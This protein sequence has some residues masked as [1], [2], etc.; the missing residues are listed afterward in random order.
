MKDAAI[1]DRYRT[2]A[3]SRDAHVRGKNA[4]H[5]AARCTVLEAARAKGHAKKE[6][7]D[8]LQSTSESMI[9]VRPDGIGNL[10]GRYYRLLATLSRGSTKEA[11]N[12]MVRLEELREDAV[13]VL[14]FI[15]SGTNA[16]F[17]KDVRYR[18]FL[19]ILLSLEVKDEKLW[20]RCVQSESRK[21]DGDLLRVEQNEK[22]NFCTTFPFAV[23]W[24]AQVISE[25]EVL[26]KIDRGTARASIRIVRLNR[27]L[28]AQTEKETENKLFFLRCLFLFC[29]AESSIHLEESV[30]HL[31][32]YGTR[33]PARRRIQ[34]SIIE[35]SS[36]EPES[37]Y[38]LDQ[39]WLVKTNHPMADPE[40]IP[41]NGDRLPLEASI[42]SEHFNMFDDDLNWDAID[43]ILSTLDLLAP[44]VRHKAQ[45]NTSRGCMSGFSGQCAA[46]VRRSVGN[47]A[48]KISG[49]G[50][51]LRENIDYEDLIESKLAE[52]VRRDRCKLE[53]ADTNSVAGCRL[54]TLMEKVVPEIYYDWSMSN[55][56]HPSKA[57]LQFLP[58]TQYCASAYVGPSHVDKI[59]RNFTYNHNAFN[60]E[61]ETYPLANSIFFPA[62]NMSSSPQG[63]TTD[64]VCPAC[65]HNAW[66]ILRP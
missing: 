51:R 20:G 26:K 19:F 29:F 1:G 25:R 24:I 62:L 54:L 44:I 8:E 66:P 50:K 64:N 59:D 38:I 33:N 41:E 65:P 40:W 16:A 48:L 32:R 10:E 11:V 52:G 31:P 6:R 56:E 22:I 53:L 15:A 35:P 2:F 43:A 9:D 60:E 13:E 18:L 7:W 45:A 23:E 28:D 47:F 39:D 14:G 27:V 46:Q 61:R 30:S 5:S 58:V 37:V 3:V 17:S 63:R 42:A 55:L 4:V 36:D 34:M 49:L 21:V 12:M 57:N